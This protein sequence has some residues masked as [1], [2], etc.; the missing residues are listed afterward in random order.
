[1][2]CKQCQQQMFDYLDKAV[3]QK[4]ETAI[5][6]HLNVCSHCSALYAEERRFHSF[7]G[8][9][10]ESITSSLSVDDM[11]SERLK[12]REQEI[13]EIKEP[14]MP[15]FGDMRRLALRPVGLLLALCI[16][17]AV[18][19]L[20]SSQTP[21]PEVGRTTREA[22]AVTGVLVTDSLTDWHERRLVIT[23]QDEKGKITSRIVTSFNSKEIILNTQT[24]GTQSNGG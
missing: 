4:M 3:S 8:E 24:N 14:V 13:Q 17:T 10:M 16:I 7:L 21:G 20:V 12:A 11:L 23:V 22:E 9:G 19:W 2:K 6:G 1:M 15:Y 18:I 5:D